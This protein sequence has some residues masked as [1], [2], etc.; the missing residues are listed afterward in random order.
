MKTPA[1]SAPPAGP[2]PLRYVLSF[3]SLLLLFL[4]H[5]AVA[6]SAP[7]LTIEDDCA[8]L[9]FA[10]DGR[11]AYAVRHIFSTRRIEMQ[12][13]DIWVLFPDGRRKRIVNG[14][15]LV[16]GDAPF[17]YLVQSMRW[18]PDATRLTVELLTS[19]MTDDRG[20]TQEGLAT[21]LIDQNGKEL[22]IQGA[23]SAIWDATGGAWLAD[24]VTVVYLVEAVKPRLLFAIRSVRPIAGRGGAL[25]ERLTFAAVAWDPARNSAVAVERD[26]DLTGPP[27]LVWLDL[28][29]ETRRELAV[30]DGFLG[31]LTISPS[32][33]RVAYF[34]D[35]DT[36]EI[37]EL[38]EPDR[39]R[40]ARVAF[41][42]YR[43]SAD[44][45]RIL[46]KR[47]QPNRSGILVWV[48]LADGK[49]EPV[50]HSLTFRDFALAP[51][52]RSLAV[53]LPS[54]NLQLHP[55]R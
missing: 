17:S 43:W 20:T 33:T 54:R 5:P 26:K 12:R 13:D 38:A 36:L 49:I 41:G 21:L 18:S 51:D 27:R 30:L 15:K 39:V 10:P 45:S 3:S 11:L 4:P 1:P 55:L 40:R 29:K 22:K 7:T 42:A 24:G 34:R 14:E 31:G 25:F 46:L 32:G 47:G 48:H 16:E 19:Q 6:Q 37:R 53:T 9:A 44:E 52:G 35:A 8:A 50:L 28:T 2:R 23:D